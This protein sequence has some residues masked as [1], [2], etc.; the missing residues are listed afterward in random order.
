MLHPVWR[1]R[2]SELQ[3]LRNNNLISSRT[4]LEN[5]LQ[6]L[7]YMPWNLNHMSCEQKPQNIFQKLRVAKKLWITRKHLSLLLNTLTLPNKPICY[8]LFER[9]WRQC[10]GAVV[11]LSINHD[12]QENSWNHEH[13]DN[14]DNDRSTI[15]SKQM[16]YYIFKILCDAQMLIQVE[17][18][19]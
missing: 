12:V 19:N 3:T 1:S 8:I 7:G 16:T 15:R 6:N 10:P 9:G 18:T 13:T 14:Q 2:N 11:A 17:Q 5:S 4:S